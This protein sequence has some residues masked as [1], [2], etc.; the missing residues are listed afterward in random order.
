MN[1]VDFL[2]TYSQISNQFIND[3]FSLYDINDKN[4]FIINLENVVK[5]LNTK[6]GK[7]KETLEI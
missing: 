4:I 7:I 1:L 3:F 2:K 6:K 5:W